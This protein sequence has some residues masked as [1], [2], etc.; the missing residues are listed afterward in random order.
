MYNIEVKDRLF[1]QRSKLTNTKDKNIDHCSF[2]RL[3][4]VRFLR[5]TGRNATFYDKESK[6][7]FYDPRALASIYEIETVDFF[8]NASRRLDKAAEFIR[9]IN[10]KYDW[11]Q[12]KV[13]EEG[14]IKSIVNKEELKERWPRLRASILKDYK[15]DVIE[16]ALSKIDKQFGTEDQINSALSQYM[17][18]GL[19]FPRIPEKHTDNWE[20]NRFV[21]FSEYEGE[22]FEE[23]VLFL[24]EDGE[25]RIYEITGKALPE[26]KTKINEY[27]GHLIIMKNDIFPEE[28]ELNIEFVRDNIVNQWNFELLCYN[29]K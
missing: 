15:G 6:M 5:E 12:I 23:K 7:N 20:N 27:K 2:E 8:V 19:I 3:L 9:R 11:I 4:N 18:F 29:N 25:R 26:S 22:T 1:H 14:E 16:H 21:E 10:Y 28:I 24:K 17:Y 13:N